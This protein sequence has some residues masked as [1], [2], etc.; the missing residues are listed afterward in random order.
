M[1]LPMSA[2]FDR[3]NI[4]EKGFELRVQTLL[5]NFAFFGSSRDS[6]ALKYFKIKNY[7]CMLGC[8][9]FTYYVYDFFDARWLWSRVKQKLIFNVLI[10]QEI[11]FQPLTDFQ[12]RSES[13]DYLSIY[14]AESNLSCLILKK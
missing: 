1:H 6:F 11:D 9:F 2:L 7:D 12:M 10:G 4:E 14:K 3:H 8:L 13:L 5:Q